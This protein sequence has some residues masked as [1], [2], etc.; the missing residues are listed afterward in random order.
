[1]QQV[2]IALIVFAQGHDLIKRTPFG[3]SSIG[4]LV[5]GTIWTPMMPLR[6]LTQST[7]STFR[8]SEM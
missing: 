6:I 5:F 1:M 8:N 7:L 2:L 4:V 3:I